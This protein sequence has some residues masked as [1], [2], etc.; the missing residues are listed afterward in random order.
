MIFFNNSYKKIFFILCLLGLNLGLMAQDTLEVYVDTVA[1]TVDEMNPNLYHIPVRVVNMQGITSYDITIQTGAGASV[2]TLPDAVGFISQTPNDS[3]LRVLYLDLTG[4]A[5]N[6]EDDA[7][8]FT[9]DVYFE[10]GP[11]D[12]FPFTITSF[13]AVHVDDP[14][15]VVPFNAAQG[16]ICLPTVVSMSGTILKHDEQA[17]DSVSVELVQGDSIYHTVT[18]EMGQYTFENVEIGV[19]ATITPLTKLNETT[20]LERIQGINVLDLT[21]LIQHI[22]GSQLLET[23]YQ[24]IAADVNNSEDLTTV[25]LIDIQ[26]YILNRIDAFPS[27]AYYRFIDA[28]HEFTEPSNP[29]AT[30]I[31]VFITVESP[32]TDMSELHFIGVKT[33]DL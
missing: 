7:A 31:P 10:G 25:D 33:G 28:N 6:L 32:T 5:L 11:G 30:P 2:D 19:P 12:C 17:L 13:D 21:S 27:N 14:T 18:N 1:Y 26:S 22:L 16:Q 3:T 9:M 23:P 15:Q 24:L 8:I 4:G 29:W 20:R